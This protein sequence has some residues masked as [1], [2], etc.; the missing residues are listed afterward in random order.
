MNTLAQR[1]RNNIDFK[2]RAQRVL[3]ASVKLVQQRWS[4]LDTRNHCTRSIDVYEIRPRVDKHGFDLSGDALRYSPL[5]YRGSN[6]IRDAVTYA[7]SYSRSHSVVIHV[8]DAADNVV[9][10]HE[11]TGEFKEP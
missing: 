2:K 8:Y 1:R 6:A 10:T 9:E 5:W 7:K 4:K 3:K 11:H